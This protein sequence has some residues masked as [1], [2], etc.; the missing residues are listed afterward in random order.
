MLCS[1]RARSETR[2]RPDRSKAEG[3]GRVRR[4]RARGGPRSRLMTKSAMHATFLPRACAYSNIQL[5]ISNIL[6]LVLNLVDLFRLTYLASQIHCSRVDIYGILECTCCSGGIGPP[7]P[8]AFRK[9]QDLRWDTPDTASVTG[10]DL[11]FLQCLW[12]GSSL[13]SPPPLRIPAS[14][15]PGTAD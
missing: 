13:N 1:Y 8:P 11:G 3:T 15:G 9:I 4:H 12:Y 6:N 14:T 10:G 5:Y 7:A 2:T